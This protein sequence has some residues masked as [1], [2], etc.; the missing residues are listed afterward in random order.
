MLRSFKNVGDYKTA[1]ASPKGSEW[2][3]G[4]LI[5]VFHRAKWQFSLL[6]LV[7]EF[8]I[9]SVML[10][11]LEKRERHCDNMLKWCKTGRNLQNSV[12]NF[13]HHRSHHVNLPLSIIFCIGVTWVLE[14]I[15]FHSKIHSISQVKSMNWCSW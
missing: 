6:S 4:H 3:V 2:A 9:E 8:S 12:L 11:L 13:N 15:Y 14:Q 5:I 1:G 10:N 7:L